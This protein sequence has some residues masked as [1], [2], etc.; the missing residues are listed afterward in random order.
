MADDFS[1]IR[2][3]RADRPSGE[4]GSTKLGGAPDWIQVEWRPECCGR[5]M[6]FLGQFDSL[7]IPAAELPDAALVYIFFC[8]ECFETASQLQCC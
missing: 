8:S 3:V 7:D 6:R 5:R 2:L 4:S 1:E